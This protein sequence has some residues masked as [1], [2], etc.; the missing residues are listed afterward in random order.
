VT[1]LACLLTLSA[2]AILATLATG[3]RW[4][5]FVYAHPAYSAL[6]VGVTLVFLDILRRVVVGGLR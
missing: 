4:L 2:L 1:L 3:C 6:F 5:A